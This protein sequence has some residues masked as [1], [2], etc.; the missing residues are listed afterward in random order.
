MD[1]EQTYLIKARSWLEL[2]RSALEHNIDAISARIPSGVK[3]I[4]V[5]KANAYGH[6]ASWLA[7]IALEKGFDAFAVATLEEAIDLR[8][9][10]IK[11]PILILSPYHQ[12]FARYLIDYDLSQTVSS[13]WEVV[14]L[15]DDLATLLVKFPQYKN[16]RVKIH[17]KLDTGMN[18]I[19]FSARKSDQA[20]TIQRILEISQQPAIEIRGIFSHFAVADE[21]DDKSDEFTRL[22]Y[23][24]FS[25]VVA[26]CKREGLEFPVKHCANSAAAVRFPEYCLDAVRIGISLYGCCPNLD[27]KQELGLE[28]VMSLFTRVS[29]IHAAEPQSPVGYGLTYQTSP[30]LMT[31]IATVELGYAD[32]LDRHLSNQAGMM[33]QGKL[34][35]II[36]RICM[37]RTMLD[38]SAVENLKVGDPVLVFGRDEYGNYNDLD[39][40]AA[41]ADT[42]SY[43]ILCGMSHRLKRLY[44]G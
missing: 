3:K 35:P 36:G 24:R 5:V 19:G 9:A 31:K 27:L 11:V 15:A 34:V 29:S 33:I 25:E 40:L 6:G 22:Q 18:R 37:D 32:G 7:P 2:S 28:P 43:T 14:R 13:S 21:T 23:Q 12:D 10:K 4:A 44:L 20:K 1:S 17:V 30:G 41:K 16:R 38:V 8:K 39:L 26:G 42:I